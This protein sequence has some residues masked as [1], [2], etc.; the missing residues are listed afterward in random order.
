MA[1]VTVVGASGSFIPVTVNGG[2][3]F[4]LAQAY[5][6]A[7][8]SLAAN[9]D[10][11]MQ[12]M[13][14]SGGILPS[15][16]GGQSGEAVILGGGRY[17]FPGGYGYVTDGTTG[18]NGG[19]MIDESVIASSTTVLAG[20]G[21]TTVFGGA[22]GGTFIGGGGSNVFEG[23]STGGGNY[24]IATADGNDSIYGNSGNDV[25]YA[26]TGSNQI[27]AG[28]GND[29]IFSQ[30][31][32]S[33]V[34]GS[35][36]DAVN[37]AGSS[38]TVFGASGPLTVFDG[39]RGN[40]VVGGT[41]ATLL[42]DGTQGA[43]FVGANSTVVGGSADTVNAAGDATVFGGNNSF[44]TQTSGSLTFIA[45]ATLD[46][47]INAGSAATVFGASN[48]DLTFSS[49]S[50]LSY[51]IAATGNETLNGAAASGALVM[52]GNG[53][54]TDLLGGAG[55]DTLVSGT[56]NNTLSG[57]AGSNSF[58]FANGEAGGQDVITDFGSSAGNMVGLF[59][60]G[61]DAVQ[62]ALAGATDTAQGGSVISLSDNTTITF[63]DLTADQL[64]QHGGQF[65]SS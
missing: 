6:Q 22:G 45:N 28:T 63:T 15:V 9:G 46:D 17:T 59:G 25:I 19:A 61:A 1:V 23:L 62:A 42:F 39:G 14:P 26:G 12:V 37:L 18:V 35:G 52:F 31:S 33:V 36:S 51:L 20:D 53:S 44:I 16:P 38:A 29:T 3:A 32:D 5:A 48:A 8:N 56:G 43:Y 34:A 50:G 58:V 27:F 2:V 10:L 47:T 64:R 21:G 65:F 55:N 57:G 7:L 41:G 60:Y 4:S 13:S 49:S 54:S 30:G 24:T 11:A 40:M